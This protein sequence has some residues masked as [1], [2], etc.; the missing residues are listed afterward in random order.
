MNPVSEALPNANAR[1]IRVIATTGTERSNFFPDVPTMVA[2]GYKDVVV[3]GYT[4]FYM[5]AKTPPQIVAKFNAA[6][7]GL[8]KTEE[9]RHSLAKIGANAFTSTSEEFGQIIRRELER[10]GPVAKA[11]G[12]TGED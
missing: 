6:V 8:L 12:F 9:M 7:T 5:P 2:S 11:S 3:I 10:W 4:G 1:K